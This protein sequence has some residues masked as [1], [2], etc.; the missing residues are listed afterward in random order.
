MKGSTN[1]DGSRNR[2]DEQTIRIYLL[3]NWIFG[4]MEQGIAASGCPQ[5][6]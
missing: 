5:T 3:K 4:K 1:E 6:P 2:K